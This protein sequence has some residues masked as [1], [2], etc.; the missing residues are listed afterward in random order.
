VLAYLPALG[1]DFLWDDEGHVTRPELRSWTGLG[2]IWTEVGATQQYYPLLHS[3]FWVQHRLWGDATVGYHLSNVLWHALSALLLAAVLRRLGVPGAVLAAFAFAL[4]PVAVE[5]VAW[6]A[7]QKNTLST[8]FYLGA[9]LLWL[10]FDATRRPGAYA[11]A[12]ALFVAALLTKTVTATLPAA[13]LVIAWWRR[14]TLGWRGDVAPLLPWFALGIGAGLGTAWLETNQIGA[15]AGELAPPAA[16]V[17]LAGR[18]LWF[19]LG[20]VL[21]PADL[22]FFYPRWTIDPGVAWQWLFPLTALAVLAGLYLRRARGRGPLAAALLWGGTLF[23]ALGFVDVYPFVFS[24]V[25]DHFQYL[26]LPALLAFLA[27]AAV[28][29]WSARGWSPGAGRAVALC[30]LAG[31][32]VLTW[33]Q[34][35]HYRDVVALYEATLASNPDSWAAHLNLGTHLV[36]TGRPADG[37]PHLQRAHALRPGTPEVLN[38]L[39]DALQRVGRPRDALPLV[40]EALRRQPRFAAAHNTRGATLMTLGRADEGIAAFRRALEMQPGLVPA[41]VNLGWALANGGQLAA[42][43]A[44]FAEARRAAPTAPAPEFKWGLALASHGRV[45]EALPHLARAVELAPADPELRATLGRALVDAGRAAE[46]RPHLEEALRRAP[47][48]PGAREVLDRLGR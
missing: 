20:K 28:T 45:R 43:V 46:A 21:W 38:S 19:Y 47:E 32:G 25:A 33:R 3:V 23:P 5:S 16:R 7:E 34:A 6:I 11:G 39:A 22:A 35:G 29:G 18:I 36:D 17:V 15:A 8:L 44:E 12:T 42:A 13:L 4:H 9:A 31:L 14:G 27:A 26:A 10:R 24:Y 40:D 37:L 48:H 30:L 1:G 41:R 2:R